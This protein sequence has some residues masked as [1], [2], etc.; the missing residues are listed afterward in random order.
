M[1]SNSNSSDSEDS[2]FSITKSA[3]TLPRLWIRDAWKS[4]KRGLWNPSSLLKVLGPNCTSSVPPPSNEI[5]SL[6][7]RSQDV[8]EGAFCDSM[9]ELMWQCP[10]FHYLLTH[11]QKQF[12]RDQHRARASE[13]TSEISISSRSPN[14]VVKLNAR[15]WS[16]ERAYG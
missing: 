8:G 16:A 11:D 13:T 10:R 3:Q 4:I 15:R 14:E 7:H 12:Q 6:D 9:I 1:K 5:Y 2:L